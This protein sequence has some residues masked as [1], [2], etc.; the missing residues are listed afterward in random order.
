MYSEQY[1]EYAY[2]CYSLK[3]QKSYLY[4]GSLWTAIFETDTVSNL[5]KSSSL[6]TQKEKSNI[7]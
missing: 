2:W 5:K 1:G 6:K 4:Y 7:G 3:G